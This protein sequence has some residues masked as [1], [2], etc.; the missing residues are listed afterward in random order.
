MTIHRYYEHK[1]REIYANL[2]FDTVIPE[3]S[4]FKVALACR[5]PVSHYSPRTKAAAECHALSVEIV[6]RVA[7]HTLEQRVA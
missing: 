4:A 7:G 3:A 2:V 6:D 5:R 1:L